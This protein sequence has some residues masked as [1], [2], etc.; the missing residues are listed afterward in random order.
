M[1]LQCL[2]KTISLVSVNCLFR[3]FSFV[4]LS[5]VVDVDV[6]LFFFKNP[7]ISSRMHFC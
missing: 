1:H 4:C 7:F 5:F 2:T 6:F 3:L